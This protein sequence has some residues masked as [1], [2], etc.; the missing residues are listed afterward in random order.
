MKR[1]RQAGGQRRQW[2]PGDRVI[3]YIR[4]SSIGNRSETLISP[5]VQDDVCRKWAD[6]ESLVVVGEP[7]VDLD[8]TGREASK[9][10]I[11]KTINRVRRGEADGI[12]VMKVSRWGRNTID[13][14]LNVHELQEAGGFIASATENL[15]DIE[16]PMGQ[17]SL[18][19]MLAIA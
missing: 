17:F 2:K 4:V 3:I 5:D 10:E 9:R 6:R 1:T 7:V 18:T 15:D 11:S 14:M 13:S 16:T 19:Q 8:K 12:L